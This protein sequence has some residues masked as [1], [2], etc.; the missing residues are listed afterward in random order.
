M[1]KNKRIKRVP[2]GITLRLNG[3]ARQAVANAIADWL[4]ADDISHF[5]EEQRDLVELFLRE[6]QE[7]P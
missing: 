7:L 4:D 6:L 2:M 3:R 5:D 1:S